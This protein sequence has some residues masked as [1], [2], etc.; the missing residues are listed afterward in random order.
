MERGWERKVPDN[1]KFTPNPVSPNLTLALD[2]E[3]PLQLRPRDCDTSGAGMWADRARILC[4]VYASSCGHRPHCL[5]SVLQQRLLRRQACHNRLSLMFSII[6]PGASSGE[7]L[8]DGC[9]EDLALFNVN[10]G[11]PIHTPKF[12]RILFLGSISARWSMSTLPSGG[13]VPPEH[14]RFRGSRCSREHRHEVLHLVGGVIDPHPNT[15]QASAAFAALAKSAMLMCVC[16][17]GGGLGR[18]QLM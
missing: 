17:W 4:R 5:L 15:F 1:A 9:N 3:A 8:R 14:R 2:D 10:F 13:D 16:V 11:E 18:W 12:G 6:P 7:R